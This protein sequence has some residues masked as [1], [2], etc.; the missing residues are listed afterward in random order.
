MQKLLFAGLLLM[1]LLF[2]S[3]G[4]SGGDDA[5]VEKFI[6][7]ENNQFGKAVFGRTTFE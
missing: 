1:G 4:G 6:P 2:F 5:P 7:V 3:C